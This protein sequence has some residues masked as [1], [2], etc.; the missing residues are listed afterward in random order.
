MAI[1]TVPFDVTNSNLRKRF[2]TEILPQAISSLDE[3]TKPLWGEMTAQHM[4]EHLMFSF[5]MAT[6]RLDVECRTPDEKLDRMQAFLNLNRA[7]PKGFTNP[8]TGKKLLDHQFADMARAKE[9]LEKEVQYF[10]SYYKENP[11]ATHTNPMFGQLD[12]EGWMKFHFKH[13]FHHLSQFGLIEEK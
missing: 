4:V 8:V 5:R 3:D 11:K 1:I 13:C 9:A 12:A 7:M 10:L 2:L 6:D